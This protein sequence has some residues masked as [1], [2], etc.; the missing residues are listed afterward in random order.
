MALSEFEINSK[1]NRAEALAKE[2][3]TLADGLRTMASDD[4]EGYLGKVRSGWDDCGTG[5]YIGKGIRA[6]N[7][8]L[9]Q[10]K[11]LRARSSQILSLASQIRKKDFE[12]R[13]EEYG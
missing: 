8:I 4:I 11:E 6:K 9:A 1:Y 12:E 5:L 13:R 2:L 7:R 3:E 10:A